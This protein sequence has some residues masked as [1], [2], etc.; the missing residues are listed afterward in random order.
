M[1]ERVEPVL[2]AILEQPGI[3]ACVAANDRMALLVR[4]HLLRKGMRI[5]KDISVIS[6]DDSK[7]ATD[8]DLSSYSFA[9]AEIARKVLTYVLAPRP[10]H[11]VRDDSFVECEGLLIERGSSGIVRSGKIPEGMAG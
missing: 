11:P 1:A 10:K 6:F 5:S 8:N 9:F 3:T 2:N 7:A 4:D